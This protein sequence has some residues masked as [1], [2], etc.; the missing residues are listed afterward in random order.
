MSETTHSPEKAGRRSQ[1]PERLWISLA[2]FLIFASVWALLARRYEQ[3]YL[4][5]KL[6]GEIA[7]PL[8]EVDHIDAAA[9]ALEGYNVV[10]ITTDTTRADHI[11]CY[12]NR[13]VKTPVIDGLASEGILC[14]HATT[15]SPS[16]LPA[17]SSLLT[18][19]YP[20][21]HGARANG[22]F[23]LDDKVTT[24]AERLKSAGYRT[25]A[26]ISAFVLDSRFGL[27]QGFEFYH[28]DLTKGM[29][30]SAN[31]FRER[32]A[33][34]TNEPATQWLREHAGGE[35]PFFL[36]VH[37]FDPHAVYLPPEP[38]RSEYKYDL[39]DGEIAY[40][41][42]QLG[43]L[44]QQLE[45]LGVRDRTLV[46]YTSDHGEGLGEHGEQTHSLL[47]YDATLHV[48]MI[49]HAPAGLPQGK[50]IE[51]QTCLI[52]VVPTILHLL[53]KSVPEE[54]DGANLCEK[55]NEP[56]RSVLIETIA[57][58]TMHGWAPLVGVRRDDFKYILAP[59]PELYDLVGDP[60]ELKNQH[61]EHPEFVKEF[62][63][64]MAKWLGDDPYLA[65][66]GGIDVENMEVDD[67]AMRHL[68]ALGYVK[69]ASDDDVAPEQRLDPKD[70]V[71]KWEMVQK[72]I[73]TLAEGE[74]LTAIAMLEH[75]LG[76]SPGDVYARSILANAY[77]QVGEGERA[78]TNLQLAIDAEPN[79]EGLRLS[80]AGIYLQQRKF[81]EAEAAIDEAL[82]IEPE[83]AQAYLLRGQ[84]ALYR[85]LEQEAMR[86]YKQA[87]QMDPGSVGPGAH[88]A[89]G[90]LHLIYGRFDEAREAFNNAIRLDSLNGTA[91][92][93]LANIL[94]HQGKTE[95]AMRELQIALKFDPNQA[96]AL[97]TL[98]SLLSQKGDQEKALEV[99]QRALKVTPKFGTLHNNLGLIYRRNDQLDL[100]EK[101]YKLAIE[102]EPQLDA[103]YVNLAQL[104]RKQEK[105]EEAIE[106]FRAAVAATPYRPNAIALANLGVYY[107]NQGD[108]KKA[109]VH[110]L[111]ALKVN[112]D[113]A[114]VHRYVASIYDMPEYF[115]PRRVIYHL[116][117][118][119]ELDPDQDGADQLRD[120]L[121]QAEA[122]PEANSAPQ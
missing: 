102:Y 115:R 37:Y 35:K 77:Q 48:P 108:I 9:G 68:A 72:A 10:V 69:T 119:L 96:R 22:T 100:A 15:P 61:D 105:E 58:M 88:N 24:L 13:G 33:E 93:G 95:E 49:W 65:G 20:Y 53:G 86:L 109:L 44:L 70:Q 67:E 111:Q 32:A 91:H 62:S 114:L 26:V 113:Y 104:L 60:R 4:K 38:F 97:A 90:M 110:Y 18:G 106:Q 12:G 117:R 43:V 54:L 29:K 40:V 50:V 82:E 121:Q 5:E 21:H 89:M 6:T 42:S 59:T 19:L 45:A 46:V 103:A 74:P 107:F 41:D 78:M 81:E 99:A 34:L 84:I 51:R 30:Y 66:K 25:G 112:P 47:V 73:H 94:I 36:W 16:T 39:Y 17:H 57:A 3:Y 101:H 7:L 11:G 76:E 28:D 8:D 27:D 14:A 71:S 92:D 120:L 55:P 52:D 98:A 2:A 122:S 1:W 83:T 31:M 56:K 79:N 85:G 87:A 64:Q 118:T 80:V 116:R 23:R 63:G 75:A